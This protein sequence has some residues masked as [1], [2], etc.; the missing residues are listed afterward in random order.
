M[1]HGLL[2][3]SPRWAVSLSFDLY[4]TYIGQARPKGATGWGNHGGRIRDG[5]RLLLVLLER[6]LLL[7]LVMR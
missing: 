5:R 2:S 1:D 6:N 7:L 4:V 3:L